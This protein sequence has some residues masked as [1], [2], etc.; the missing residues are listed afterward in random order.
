MVKKQTGI[1]VTNSEIDVS[2]FFYGTTFI[3]ELHT[4]TTSRLKQF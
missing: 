2:Y 4:P 1:N 3:E